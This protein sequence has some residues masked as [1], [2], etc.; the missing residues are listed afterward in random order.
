MCLHSVKNLAT[1]IYRL[2]MWGAWKIVQQATSGKRS[3][4]SLEEVHRHT[5]RQRGFVVQGELSTCA[6]HLISIVD[7]CF[8]CTILGA[9]LILT[10]TLLRRSNCCTGQFPERD[11][12]RLDSEGVAGRAT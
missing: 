7:T 5:S 11:R 12:L 10:L 9:D 3:V 4:V 1:L 8:R 6:L 2:H